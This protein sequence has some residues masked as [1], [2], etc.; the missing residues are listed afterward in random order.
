MDTYKLI[1]LD[2]MEGS[3]VRRRLRRWSKSDEEAITPL[4]ESLQCASS[5]NQLRIVH[6]RYETSVYPLYYYWTHHNGFTRQKHMR[7]QLLQTLLTE[8]AT[9]PDADLLNH[10]GRVVNTEIDILIEDL[11]YFAFVEVK[12]PTPGG[13]PIWQNK[14][15]VHQLVRQYAQGKILE[16]LISK[17]FAFGTIGVNN[18][19]PLELQ[20]NPTERGLLR[21]VR[22]D[23]QSLS[24]VDS[25]W[26][27]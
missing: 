9:T 7:D 16:R 4:I 17:T 14:D 12:Q 23:R 6:P 18:G 20:L 10:V 15:G 2:Q 5:P 21:L 8:N 24:V 11:D 27:N 26:P 25:L 3:I 19:Q 1:D 13:R 22:D